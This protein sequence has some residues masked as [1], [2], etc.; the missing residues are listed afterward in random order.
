MLTATDRVEEL[1]QTLTLDEKASLTGGA[2]VWHLPAVERLGLGRLKMSDGPSGVRGESRG[3]RRSLS[4]ACGMA[5]GA[6]WDV[7]L[8]GAY[9]AA[10][11][12]EA[13]SKGVHVLLG[14]TIC[15]PRVP[16]TGRIFESFAEDPLLTARLTVAY[17]RGVQAQ[18]VACCVKHFAAN[19]QE[20]ERMS[21]SAEVEE[22]ALREIHLPAFEAAV[23]EAGV[24][25]VMSAYNRLNGTYCGEHPWLLGEVLKG[26]WGYDGV[27]V[28]DWLGTHSTVE[29]ALAGLDVEMPG[30]PSHLGSLLAAAVREGKVP[31]AVLDDHCRRILRLAERTGLL[32]SRPEEVELEEDDPQ[33]RALARRIAIE[34]SVLLKNDGLLPLPAGLR[35]LVVIGPAAEYLQTGGGGSS[36]VIPLR[37]A[38]VLDE[39]RDRLPGVELVHEEGCRIDLDTPAADALTMPDGL[40]IEYYASRDWSGEAVGSERTWSGNFVSFGPPSRQLDASGFSM[41][42]RG[43]FVPDRSGRWTLSLANTGR[44]R[45]L[46]DGEVVLDNLQPLAG[47]SMYGLGSTTIT[48]EVELA[49]GGRHDLLVELESEAPVLAGFRFG[50]RRPLQPGGIDRAVEA[51]RSA[52]ACIVVAGNNADWETEGHDRESMR[53]PGE[54]DELIRRVLAANPRTAV[55]INA[56]SPVEMPWLEAASAV[57]LAWYPGEEGAAALADVLAGVAEPGGRLPL[58]LPRAAEDL[59]AFSSYPGADG[60]VAYPEGVFVGYRDLDAREIEPAFCFGH[61]LGYTTFEYGEPSAEVAGRRVVLSVPVTNRGERPGADVVQLYVAPPAAAAP[62]PA[63]ELKGWAKVRLAAGETATVRIELDERLLSWWDGGWTFTPGRYQLLVG[64]SSRDIR[65]RLEVTLD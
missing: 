64:A 61:G 53:L 42:A 29:A 35:R 23:K 25:A 59:T 44:A 18:G 40:S 60:K 10:L 30:P 9:G 24:W 47:E 26:E 50:A 12:A 56:G 15:I 2:D 38:S 1:L 52:D 37:R 46:L 14:P 39:L 21:I 4:F 5:A 41:R 31:E 7:D 33:R 8:L 3:T 22:R 13:R 57:L 43:R 36:T 55:V 11:A 48:A 63:Q 65:H 45:V 6:T 62:R 19:D 32:D 20:H 49:A 28:S 54:Q 17:V 58:T 16:V 27:V 34:G 51:A